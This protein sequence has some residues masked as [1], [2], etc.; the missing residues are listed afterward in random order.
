MARFTATELK[1]MS[2]PYIDLIANGNGLIENQDSLQE[3][4]L[5]EKIKLII[6]LVS[7]CAGNQYQLARVASFNAAR[8]SGSQ[9][10][11]EDFFIL[12]DRGLYV[13]KEIRQLSN[14][15]NTSAY[16]FFVGM[17]DVDP[18][19]LTMCTPD[20]KLALAIDKQPFMQFAPLTR[21]LIEKDA[22]A[23]ATNL[24]TFTPPEFADIVFRVTKHT[25]PAP[26]LSALNDAF[27]HVH[28]Q[29]PSIHDSYQQF[30]FMRA[31]NTTVSMVVEEMGCQL[32]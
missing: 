30:G 11:E 31:M 4:L 32:L 18:E 28:N 1:Q 15:S 6:T 26:F 27:N 24:Y 16:N 23:I 10:D 22:K 21:V 14:M 3:L 29:T 2:E 20:E 9:V 12:L 5:E 13:E 19:T 25:F 7:S 17:A 8:A